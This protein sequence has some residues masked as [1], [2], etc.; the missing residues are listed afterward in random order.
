[1]FIGKIFIGTRAKRINTIMPPDVSV[2]IPTYNRK[3][4]LKKAISSCFDGNE[5]INI[6]VIVIDDGSTDGTREY[7]KELSDD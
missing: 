3:E 6:E 5:D 7:L 1:M 4:Y 2:V